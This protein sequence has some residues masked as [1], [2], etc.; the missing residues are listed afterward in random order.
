MQQETDW[1]FGER[2]ATRLGASN[3]NGGWRVTSLPIKEVITCFG[4]K[5]YCKTAKIPNQTVIGG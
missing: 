2:S 5:T 1:G 3:E 4:N